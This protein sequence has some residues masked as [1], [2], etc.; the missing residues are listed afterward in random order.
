MDATNEAAVQ[1]LRQLKRRDAKPFAV[2]CC[3]QSWMNEYLEISKVERD[4]LNSWR[5]AIV[6]LREKKKLSPSVN[7]GLQT[8]GVMLPYMA[9]HY[10]LFAKSDLNAIV[11]T[12][13]NKRGEPMLKDNE[14]ARSFLID[15]SDLYVEHNREIYNRV[16]DSVIRV[17][18]EKPQVMRRGRGYA[19]EPV[20]NVD[21]VDGGL[22]FGAEMTA[23]FALGIQHQIIQSQYIGDLSDYA[24]YQA[25]QDTMDRL[26]SL[27]K[28]TP[29]FLVCDSHPQYLSS[30]LAQRYA[31]EKKLPLFQVQH[32]Q[33][34]AVS[35]TVV[36]DLTEVY[37]AL[38]VGG[39]D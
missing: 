34:H 21:S 31:K 26:S 33:A 18:D 36:Y 6:L 15:C 2:M 17:I 1:R 37:L 30:Q 12:S 7:G 23:V 39:V 27:F 10:A 24:V 13:A 3:D 32:H 16:D 22:A 5:R 9:I 29:T 11:F 19:P 4:E 8:L 35:V 25:Y 14:E 20:L 28:F 38:S